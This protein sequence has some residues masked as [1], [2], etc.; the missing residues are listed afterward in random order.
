MSVVK[1]NNDNLTQYSAKPQGK[2]S[3][4]AEEPPFG[5]DKSTLA[6]FQESPLETAINNKRYLLRGNGTSTLVSN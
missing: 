6:V 5:G 4:F 2:N 1:K 3:Q